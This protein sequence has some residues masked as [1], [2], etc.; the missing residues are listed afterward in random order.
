MSHKVLCDCRPRTVGHSCDEVYKTTEVL[1]FM[2][3]LES[4]DLLALLVDVHTYIY[5]FSIILSRWNSNAWICTSCFAAPSSA[6]YG[7]SSGPCLRGLWHFE[8]VSP[9][10]GNTGKQTETVF[11]KAH[12][13]SATGGRGLWKWIRSNLCWTIRFSKVLGETLLVV[14]CHNWL[15]G[16]AWITGESASEN[17]ASSMYWVSVTRGRAEP[18]LKTNAASRIWSNSH[19]MGSRVPFG[20]WATFD[21]TEESCC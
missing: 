4:V 19:S 16:T 9:G 12:L 5:I 14:C 1:V 6:W 10:K 3:Y 15:W 13:N 7:C 21:R 2:L 18:R 8:G 20:S 11:C 17:I